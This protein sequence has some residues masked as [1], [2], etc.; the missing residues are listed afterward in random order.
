MAKANPELI[1]ALRRAASKLSKGAPYQWGHMG[2][3]NCGN[4]AQE[5]TG[6]SKGEIHAYA[7]RK[8]GDWTEQSMD[9]CVGSE[10]PMDLLISELLENGLSIEDLRNL[11]KLEDHDVLQNLPGG[12]RH[13][14]H[15]KRED[16]VVYMQS[17]ADL[18]EQKYLS[19]VP[20][21]KIEVPEEILV[22]KSSY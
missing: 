10:M 11:E 9:Y 17:W 8:Y 20:N 2:S 5:L 13:L 12:K 1:A 6:L 19:V 16:V 21:F 4:L 7:L 14:Q 15:N 18:L 22:E 3:C